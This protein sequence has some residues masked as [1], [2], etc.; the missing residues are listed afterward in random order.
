MDIFKIVAFALVTVVVYVILKDTKKEM[1]SVFIIFAGVAIFATVLSK[2]TGILDILNNII[3]STGID[4]VYLKI[5]FKITGIAYIVEFTKNICIDSNLS[6]IAGK[7]ELFGKV[8]IVSISLPIF[9]SLLTLISG[10]I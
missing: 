4:T 5:I 7:V 6:S 9:S 10:I 2:L 8:L 1:A 3:N